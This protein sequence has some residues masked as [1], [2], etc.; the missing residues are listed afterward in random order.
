MKR[1]LFYSILFI[2]IFSKDMKSQ[3][4]QECHYLTPSIGYAWNGSTIDF[5]L[6]YEYAFEN[7][8]KNIGIGG[9]FRYLNYK[10]DFY[11]SIWSHSYFYL[12]FQGNY[13]LKQNNPDL[14]PSFGFIFGYNFYSLSWDNNYDYI[15]TKDYSGLFFAA[16]VDLRYWITP[17]VGISSRLNFG[18]TYFGSFDI[19]LDLKF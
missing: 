15:D 13:H 7:Q 9:M 11:L 19:G 12:G 6:N 2:I 8:L 14:D 4:I 18:S 16:H 3:F 5:G 1:L 10:E 17:K